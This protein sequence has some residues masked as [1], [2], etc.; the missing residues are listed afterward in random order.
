MCSQNLKVSFRPIHF[1]SLS[2]RLSVV[3]FSNTYPSALTLPCIHPLTA[4]TL[5]QTNLRIIPGHSPLIIRMIEVID[6]VAEL[7]LIACWKCR[8]HSPLCGHGVIILNEV[9]INP[10]FLHVVLV[11]CFHKIA[12]RITVDCWCDHVQ[13]LNAAYVFLSFN[14]SRSFIPRFLSGNSSVHPARS[15]VL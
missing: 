13:S 5:C 14:L 6:F 2:L 1:W 15:E 4:A 8:P 12:T 3:P 10:G 7:C 11:I 9:N